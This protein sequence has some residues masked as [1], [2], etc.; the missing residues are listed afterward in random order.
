MANPEAQSLCRAVEALTRS[1]A[2]AP[3]SDV[4]T[5][6]MQGRAG[7]VL[8]FEDVSA[9]HGSLASPRSAFG[10]VMAAAFD[11][12]SPPDEWMSCTGPD[13]HALL[14]QVMLVIWREEV[15]SRFEAA[16]AVTRHGLPRT[17]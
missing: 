1:H 16:Y 8:D 7:Q 5:L 15:L 2:H 12:A 11:R 3:A 6:V 17:A 10:Q 9:E 14:R 4:L 13:A